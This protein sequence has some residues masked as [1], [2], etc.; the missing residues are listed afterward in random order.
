MTPTSKLCEELDSGVQ[1]DTGKLLAG[2]LNKHATFSRQAFYP[3]GTSNSLSYFIM[4]IAIQ[5]LAFWFLKSKDC[6]KSCG[7]SSFS[8]VSVACNI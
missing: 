7:L 4:K 5:R 3:G 6:F 8:P 2:K 1:I